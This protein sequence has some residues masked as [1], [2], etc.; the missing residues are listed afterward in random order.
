MCS[1]MVG[2]EASPSDTEIDWVAYM[3]EVKG[4]IDGQFDYSQLKGQT[5]PLVYPA[6][7][8]YI[9]SLLFW[10]TDEG[11]NVLRAQ[12]IFFGI[13]MVFISA[14]FYVYSKTEVVRLFELFIQSCLDSTLD[15][16]ICVLL[17]K[18]SLHIRVEIIQRL[19]CNDVSVHLYWVVHQAKMVMGV[20]LVQVSDLLQGSL[21][22][23]F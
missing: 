7:F 4:V 17:S 12:Y 15:A 3:E 19:H 22:L 13:Y 2:I 18:D 1:Y 9:Y 14:V 11:S 23:T 5:G 20:L 6:G 10:A 8:V 16:S 21:A